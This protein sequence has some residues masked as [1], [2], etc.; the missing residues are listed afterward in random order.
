[1]EID[2]SLNCDKNKVTEDQK[3]QNNKE[4]EE[5]SSVFQNVFLNIKPPI[6][7]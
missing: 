7:K 5:A 1:M 4:K 2:E 3:E 6:K